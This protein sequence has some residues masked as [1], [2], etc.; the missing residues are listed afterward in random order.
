MKTAELEVGGCQETSVHGL[1]IF[2]VANHRRV[3]NTDNF[4]SFNLSN[5]KKVISRISWENISGQNNV[6]GRQWLLRRVYQLSKSHHQRKGHWLY[7]F[8]LLRGSHD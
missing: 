7:S 1:I 6:N 5:L 4:K 3:P 8:Q 2:S